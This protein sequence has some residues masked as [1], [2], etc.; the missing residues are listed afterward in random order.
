[1]RGPVRF[2]LAGGAGPDDFC[3]VLIILSRRACTAV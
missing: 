1:V 3:S 2:W